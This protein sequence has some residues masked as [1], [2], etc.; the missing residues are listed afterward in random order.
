M[1]AGLTDEETEKGKVRRGREKSRG[2]ER[3]EEE[4]I[5][6]LGRGLVG[7]VL[8]PRSRIARELHNN[9]SRNSYPIPSPVTLVPRESVPS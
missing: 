4:D 9:A 1:G 5:P 8:K 7:V 2:E 6:G 3:E